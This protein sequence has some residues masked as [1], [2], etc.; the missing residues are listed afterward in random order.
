MS[1]GFLLAKKLIEVFLEQ[2]KAV[3]KDTSW[4]GTSSYRSI[5][6]SLFHFIGYS[7]PGVV[8]RVE[9]FLSSF[10]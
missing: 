3:A 8:S 9:N 5:C 6:F 1:S 10:V 2:T 7:K 4:V